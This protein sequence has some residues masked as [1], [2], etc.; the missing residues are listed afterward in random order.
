MGVAAAVAALAATAGGYWLV[1]PQPIANCLQP[2]VDA[3]LKASA[4]NPRLMEL[5]SSVKPGVRQV[6]F[7]RD[8]FFAC[9]RINSLAQDWPLDADAS[10]AYDTLRNSPSFEL[11]RYITKLNQEVSGLDPER[12]LSTA[13]LMRTTAEVLEAAAQL[14]GCADLQTAQPDALEELV[15]LGEPYLTAVAWNLGLA[16]SPDNARAGAESILKVMAPTVE[17]PTCASPRLETVL[18]NL[19]AFKTGQLAGLPCHLEEGPAT[20]GLE[21]VCN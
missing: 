13:K 14:K 9:T 5:G 12:S 4:D 2:L 8:E 17:T 10:A 1:N 11:G 21:L 19:R 3:D 18:S 20:E 7:E 15:M 6:G 16:T